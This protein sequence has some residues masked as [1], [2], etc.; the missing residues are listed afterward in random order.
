MSHKNI[1]L[2]DIPSV[3]ENLLPKSYTRPVADFLLGITSIRAKWERFLPG[4]YSYLTVDYLREKYPMRETSEG[5]ILVASNV[6]PTSELAARVASLEPGEALVGENRRGARFTIAAAGAPDDARN[7][8]DRVPDEAEVWPGRVE[9]V[10]D[11]YDVF[12]L[13]G[14]Q[15]EDDFAE[16]TD[17]KSVV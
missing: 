9:C 2:Y 1:I 15:I 12:L 3:R 16:L 17:R 6:I 7:M 10:R 13:N 14:Q 8:L 5:N 4:D 11:L